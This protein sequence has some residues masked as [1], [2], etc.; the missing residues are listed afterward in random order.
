MR[1]FCRIISALLLNSLLLFGN[2]FAN[3]HLSH[4]NLQEAQFSQKLT[5]S[6]LQAAPQ[7]LRLP[8]QIFDAETGL[9][10][11]DRRYYDPETGRYQSRDPIGFEGGI[12]L[13]S[14]A[15][16]NPL[17]YT[18]ATG[19]DACYVKFPDYPIELADGVKVTFLPGG[20]A[21]VLTFD[22][23]TGAT[24][25]YEYG[26]YN[27]QKGAKAPKSSKEGNVLRGKVPKLKMDKSG[28]PTD[29]SLQGMKEYLAKNY[30]KGT[31]AELTCEPVNQS[32]V[33]EFAENFM[34]NPD[35]PNY[36]WFPANH[37]QSFARNAIGAGK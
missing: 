12:N 28:N 36:G 5:Q 19:E 29:K 17:F 13:Y 2:A 37:C 34:N 32:K 30:G 15:L 27:P 25:Y 18:D 20:H 35:R 26:R 33:N 22:P 11:N 24:R 6:R 8:G 7:A 31:K 4:S 23:K 1:R 10:Y 21:G 9:H 16:A 14:Y 3:S